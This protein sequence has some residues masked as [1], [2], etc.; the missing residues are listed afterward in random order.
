MSNVAKHYMV[1]I[2]GIDKCGKGT[3]GQYLKILGNYKY[4]LL[5]RGLLSNI[6]Y[7]KLHGRGYQYDLS[8]YKN[9][10]VVYLVVEYEDWKV[11]CKISNEPKID[12]AAHIKAFNDA[13]AELDAAGIKV[14]VYSTSKHNP[15]LIAK[16]ILKYLENADS[17]EQK[18]SEEQEK[19][20]GQQ[21][22]AEQAHEALK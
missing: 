11:R 3:V 6:A 1:S 20:G 19:D 17:E 18:K 21:A 15:Y 2:E 7:S 12:F 10:V 4:V 5:D 16:D 9:V 22:A 13:A 14:L 8:Q